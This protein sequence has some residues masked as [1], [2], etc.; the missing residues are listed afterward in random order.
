MD[1]YDEL[2]QAIRR[3]DVEATERL[4]REIGKNMEADF[5]REAFCDADEWELEI[6]VRVKPLTIHN[7]VVVGCD[8]WFYKFLQGNVDMKGWEMAVETID[9][10][11]RIVAIQNKVR[12]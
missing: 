10:P 7:L 2:D 1:P 3:R 5:W 6:L 4:Y 12:V 8:A 9:D 11:E